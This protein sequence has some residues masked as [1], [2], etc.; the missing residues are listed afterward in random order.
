MIP[1]PLEI[2]LGG[3]ILSIRPLKL[4]QLRALKDSVIANRDKK[5]LDTLDVGTEIICIATGKDEDDVAA[6]IPEIEVAAQE[7]LKFAGFQ[8]SGEAPGAPVK[9]PTSDGD[10]YTGA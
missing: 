4:K 3:E 10:S 5:G 2:T 6:T 1:K 9:T 7:I 8:V